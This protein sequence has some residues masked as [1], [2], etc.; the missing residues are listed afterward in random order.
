[1]L[2]SQ[3]EEMGETEILAFAEDCARTVRQAEVDLLQAAYQWAVVHD[4]ARLDPAE[5]GRPVVSGRGV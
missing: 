5:A 3:L 1:M 2:G 4:P